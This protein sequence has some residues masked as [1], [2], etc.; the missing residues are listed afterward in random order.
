M[1]I[2]DS[3]GKLKKGKKPKTSITLTAFIPNP[4]EVDYNRGYIRRFF[5]QPANDKSGAITEISADSYIRVSTSAL[6]RAV[7]LRWRIRGPLK[8]VFNED[9]TVADKGVS[10]SNRLAIK[11]VQNEI[12]NL[13]LYLPHLLQFYK[14]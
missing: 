2:L 3:Y 10:E 13:K 12:P 4:T 6:Y 8:M 9:S 7:T 5:A 11:G 14:E 1:S